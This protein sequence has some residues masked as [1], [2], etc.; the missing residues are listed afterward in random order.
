MWYQCFREKKSRGGSLAT[1]TEGTKFNLAEHQ[2]LISHFPTQPGV[3]MNPEDLPQCTNP[4]R[5][6]TFSIYK[7]LFQ[8]LY[9]AQVHDNKL[10]P[11]WDQLWGM[12]MDDLK[13]VMKTRAPRIKKETY[14]E[15]INQMFS[16]CTIVERH[17]ETEGKLWDDSADSIIIRSTNTN[18]RHRFSLLMLT[19]GILQ[20]E[21]LHRAELSDFLMIR[22]PRQEKDVH[23]PIV[24]I[25]AISCSRQDQP[26][27]NS[28][29]KSDT[30]Q[31]CRAL[32]HGSTRL[33]F[34]FSVLLH[35]R[36]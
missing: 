15:K 10:P 14:Q 17:G 24:M 30:A 19:S 23:Q 1:R 18:L 12:D 27:K 25:N 35:K 13:N 9:K 3:Q 16:P 29:W 5:Y 22:S 21:S 26:R 34:V 7:A 11:T 8:K 31:G 4:P 28:F 36:I 33:L 32:L 6:S 20:C 2:K